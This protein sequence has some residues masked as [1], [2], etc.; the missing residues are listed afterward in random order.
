MAAGV[1]RTDF[2]LNYTKKELY[3]L[4]DIFVYELNCQLV[5][6]IFVRKLEDITVQGSD[7]GRVDYSVPALHGKRGSL[8]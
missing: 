4:Q 7:L 6:R 1:G 5:M 2:T 3:F 8:P